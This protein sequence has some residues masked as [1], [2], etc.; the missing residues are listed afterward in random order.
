MSDVYVVSVSDCSAS[1]AHAMRDA[2]WRRAAATASAGS[3]GSGSGSAGRSVGSAGSARRLRRVS[4]AMRATVGG[5][6]Y[7]VLFLLTLRGREP[8]RASQA[9][10]GDPPKRSSRELWDIWPE[11][12]HLPVN[13]VVR[14]LCTSRH[15]SGQAVT[16]EGSP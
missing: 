15:P 11:G 10:R 7:G 4:G 5:G 13:A 9:G 1:T 2:G 8:P 12:I 3:P 6:P 16:T 14:A